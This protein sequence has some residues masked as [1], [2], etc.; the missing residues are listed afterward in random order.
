MRIWG[1]DNAH[2]GKEGKEV[3]VKQPGDVKDIHDLVG[4]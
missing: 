2:G 1:Y 3:K 4:E